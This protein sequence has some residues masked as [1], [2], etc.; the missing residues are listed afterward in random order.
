MKLHAVVKTLREE[1]EFTQEQLAA[2][3][4]LT[5]GYISRLEAGNYTDGSPSIRTLQRIAGGLSVPL[6]VILHQAGITRDG[7]MK[8]ADTP[9]FLR[10]KYDFNVEQIGEVEQ[11]IDFVKNKITRE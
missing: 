7:Y 6:E 10:V 1:H 2:K 8:S 11:F 9:T 5:R 4:G 3:S